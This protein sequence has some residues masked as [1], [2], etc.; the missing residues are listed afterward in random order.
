MEALVTYVVLVFVLQRLLLLPLLMLPFAD[1]EAAVDVL[2]VA[3]AGATVAAAVAVD[4]DCVLPP[5][6]PHVVADVI[7]V[8]CVAF[9]SDV[10]DDRGAAIVLLPPLLLLLFQSYI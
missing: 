1:I 8:V 2:A 3:G 6:F 4:I 9:F 5:L 7:G 10:G